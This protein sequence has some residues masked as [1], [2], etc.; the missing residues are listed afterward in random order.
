MAAA[1]RRELSKWR[2]DL[3]IWKYDVTTAIE[4]D[5][6]HRTTLCSE[7]CVWYALACIRSFAIEPLFIS[8]YLQPWSEVNV[9]RLVG[10][11]HCVIHTIFGFCQN[12]WRAYRRCLNIS[13]QKAQTTHI[14]HTD[15]D[16]D[17]DVVTYTHLKYRMEK[18]NIFLHV[19]RGERITW[20]KIGSFF[21]CFFAGTFVFART[22]VPSAK[23]IFFGKI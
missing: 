15:D 12:V 19:K 13:P 8:L 14:A 22:T 2:T 11:Q 18:E 10:T 17:N 9:L 20:H 7:E 5:R 21:R 3:G 16:D 23:W 4:R 6:Q 1:S